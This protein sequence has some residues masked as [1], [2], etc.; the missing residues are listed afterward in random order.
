MILY[1]IKRNDFMRSVLLY[2]IFS[3]YFVQLFIIF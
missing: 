2:M 1:S 3:K